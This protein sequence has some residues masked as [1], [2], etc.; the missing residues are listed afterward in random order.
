MK[1][2][3]DGL[4]LR[5]SAVGESD[6]LLTVLTAEHGKITLRAKGVRNMKSKNLS[7]GRAFVYANFEYYEKNEMCWLSGGSIHRSFFA[8]GGEL[9]DVA[10]ASY[11]VDV[12]GEITGEGV[13]AETILRTTLNTLHAIEKKIKPRELIKGAYELFAATRSGFSPEIFSCRECGCESAESFF[14]DVMNGNIV[15]PE[16]LEKSSSGKP[17]ADVDKY[18]ARNILISV[19]MSALT[20]ARYVITAKPERLLAFE[21]KG[22][23]DLADFSR[24]GETYLQNHLEK[25]FETLAFYKA[26]SKPL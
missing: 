3:I 23:I 6:K 16:C 17:I 22:E 24:L 7:L 2:A 9:E 4:V 5:E 21:L 11:I 15:C 8:D 1:K 25:G 13:K 26:V 18:S 10:L 12:A 19:S 14:V 20:A